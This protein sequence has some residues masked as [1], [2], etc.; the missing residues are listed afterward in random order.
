MGDA[1]G[2]GLG[3]RGG[4]A[5]AE[6]VEA[7]GVGGQGQDPTGDLIWIDGWIVAQSLLPGCWGENEQT[8]KNELLLVGLTDI[9]LQIVLALVLGPGL[10]SSY[11]VEVED[12]LQDDDHHQRYRKQRQNEPSI[13]HRLHSL[14]CKAGHHKLHEQDRHD[15]S[16]VRP[17]QSLMPE[18]A[19]VRDRQY[20]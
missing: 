6:P 15:L 10:S 11:L 19:F 2:D 12:V 5:V 7:G 20:H 3:G 8:N 13:D 14:P 9:D 16:S 18:T 17:L 4:R 1:A